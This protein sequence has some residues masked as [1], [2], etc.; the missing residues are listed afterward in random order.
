LCGYYVGLV[1]RCLYLLFVFSIFKENIME[2][3]HIGFW[4]FLHLNPFIKYA[5][6]I[7]VFLLM[8]SLFYFAKTGY[9]ITK[10][11]ITP[12]SVRIQNAD[13]TLRYKKTTPIQ[14]SKEA[15][16]K[17]VKLIKPSINKMGQISVQSVSGTKNLN[18]GANY[19]QVGDN[20]NGIKP[21]DV[22]PKIIKNIT[23]NF[24]KSDTIVIMV[25][26]DAESNLFA[27]KIYFA[28]KGLN[29]SNIYLHDYLQS[30]EAGDTV[31]VTRAP[32]E[33]FSKYIKKVVV[34]PPPKNI[35]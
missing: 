34:I 24:N 33:G 11:G 3:K 15:Q 27:K 9:S 12:P 18:I 5:L 21:R 8:G 20:Y 10:D 1:K 29:Y 2:E 22:T 14:V 32:T 23:S 13:T 31:E 4:H 19:G 30:G 7:A 28:L 17:K 6:L 26:S 35:Q 25:T 16:S